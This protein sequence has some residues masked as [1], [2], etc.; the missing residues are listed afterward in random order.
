MSGSFASGVRM[1]RFRS[2]LKRY[3]SEEINQNDA[4]EMLGVSERT[5]RRWCRPLRRG[6]RSWAAGSPAGPCLAQADARGRRSQDR[7]AIPHALWASGSNGTESS[8]RQK[9]RGWRVFWSL[10]D[11]RVNTLLTP[12]TSQ[13]EDGHPLVH[14]TV[15]F[16]AQVL[17]TKGSNGCGKSTCAQ[18]ARVESKTGQRPKASRIFRAFSSGVVAVVSISRS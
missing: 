2:V 7:T 15:V 17:R 1:V 18:T 6:R 14:Q 12:P 13:T 8:I 11:A 16:C 9:P 3:E 10:I 4:A 5:F